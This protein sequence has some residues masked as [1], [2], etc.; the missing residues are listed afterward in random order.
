MKLDEFS[1]SLGSVMMKKETILRWCLTRWTNIVREWQTKSPSSS[2]NLMNTVRRRRR[3]LFVFTWQRTCGR[4]FQRNKRRKYK[5][6]V[7]GRST[8]SKLFSHGGKILVNFSPYPSHRVLTSDLSS[9][10]IVRT[11]YKFHYPRHKPWR[12]IPGAEKLP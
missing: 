12:Q 2:S 11:S 4:N 6:R 3:W 9:R 10:R 1:S 5:R 8:G 7:P